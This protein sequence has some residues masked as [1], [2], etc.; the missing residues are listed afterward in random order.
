MSYRRVLSV[1]AA[2]F[3]VTAALLL[4]AANATA[5]QVDSSLHTSINKCI[6]A[7]VGSGLEGYP[8][9]SSRVIAAR[10]TSSG[11]VAYLLACV[12][13]FTGSS[14]EPEVLWGGVYACRVTL[15]GDNEGGELK[16]EFCMLPREGENSKNDTALMFSP[17]ARL[18]ISQLKKSD[19]LLEEFES[20]N[21]A[22]AVDYL[23]ESEKISDYTL[24]LIE[25][26][27]NG[28]TL[29]P[30]RLTKVRGR[31]I[32]TAFVT[33]STNEPVCYKSD[34]SLERLEND[35]L[36]KLPVRKGYSFS[37]GMVVIDAE[38]SDDR[39][40]YLNAFF[41]DIQP[42]TYR[43]SAEFSCGIKPGEG[44]VKTADMLFRVE[45]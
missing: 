42:G 30:L 5:L 29:E 43:L 8:V 38:K 14:Q 10:K 2:V 20:E 45:E 25:S 44:E 22:C 36:V 18:K 34:F 9:A 15:A 19:E 7:K 6:A 16:P 41:D 12:Q 1:L 35:K 33:N 17:L 26:S 39:I 27:Q 3:A 28:V 37:Q 11:G 23:K 4:V 32:L 24:Y 31:L 40:F 21:L 13:G